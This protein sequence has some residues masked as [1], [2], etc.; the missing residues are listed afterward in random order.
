MAQ[1]FKKHKQIEEEIDQFLD[2][3]VAAG[4]LFK[5]GIQLYLEKR[6]DE[7]ENRLAELRRLEKDADMLRR[8]IE[9]K[10]YLRT[11][12]PDSRG[13]VLGLLEHS[14]S[15]LNK[16]ADNLLEYSVEVPETLPELN[17]LHN[18]LADNA[19]R[20]S[21]FM[22]KAIRAYF[23]DIAAV[24]DH[25]KQ[26]QFCREETNRLAEKYK[27]VLFRRS[28]LRLSHRIHLRYFTFHIE[29][30]ADESEDVCDRL[31]IATIKRYI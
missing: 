26:V 17:E 27:R 16:I 28:D 10:L 15:V 23:R 1:L 24:R 18:E 25:I 29:Q 19:I 13:D 4:L 3:I 9:T 7:F 22:V 2:I 6:M 12:I 21:E 14:D 20:A 30:I 5:K 8:N 11:L 31:A